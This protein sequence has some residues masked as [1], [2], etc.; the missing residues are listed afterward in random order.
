MATDAHIDTLLS[1]DERA[2]MA[3]L[4]AFGSGEAAPAPAPAPEP[5]PAPAPAD[6]PAAPPAPAPAAAKPPAD[7]PPAPA[8]EAPPAPPAPPAPASEPAPAPPAEAP[9][10]VAEAS[11]AD[12]D[13]DEPIYLPVADVAPLK[14]ELTKAEEQLEQ[15]AVKVDAGDMTQADAIRESGKVNAQIARLNADIRAAETAEQ[16]NADI[17]SKFVDKTLSRFMADPDNK[18]LYVKDSPAWHAMDTALKTVGASPAN[19]GKSYAWVVREA[20]R[21]ARAMVNQP[22]KAA[23]APVAAAPPA[24]AAPAA[25]AAAKPTADRHSTTPV[26][27]TLGSLPAAAPEQVT[28]E[29]GYLDALTGVEHEKALAKLTPDQMARYL[30]FA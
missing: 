7:A 19:Q 23:G 22:R 18:V 17:S 5:A 2:A 14:T 28:G 1:A 11:A 27:T 26:P 8:A 6:P 4:D 30:S 24:P 25:P 10:P 3:E 20:D 12:T 29:F 13:D 9:A 16:T 15:I 21:V